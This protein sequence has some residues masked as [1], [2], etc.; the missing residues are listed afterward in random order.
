ML[1]GFNASLEE[2]LRMAEQAE[3][4]VSRLQ[5]LASEA[6]TLRAEKIKSQKSAERGQTPQRTQVKKSEPGNVAWLAVVDGQDK[7]K[8]I[9]IAKHWIKNYSNI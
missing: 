1:N 9:D 7:G 6:P 8:R 2:K 4:E 3:Q 5:P